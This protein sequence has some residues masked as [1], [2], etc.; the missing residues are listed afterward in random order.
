MKAIQEVN[1]AYAV[2]LRSALSIGNGNPYLYEKLKCERSFH[3]SLIDIWY[4]R[5]NKSGVKS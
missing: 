4:R 5:H 2:L 3:C 1:D